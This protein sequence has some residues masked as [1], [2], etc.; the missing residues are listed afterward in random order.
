MHYLYLQQVL[1][2][3]IIAKLHNIFLYFIYILWSIFLY[4]ITER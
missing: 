2:F 4:L 1:L 3:C